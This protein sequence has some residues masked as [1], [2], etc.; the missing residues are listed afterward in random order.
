MYR[1]MCWVVENDHTGVINGVL[2][3]MFSLSLFSQGEWEDG[4]KAMDQAI[5][6][7]PRT[8]HRL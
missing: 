3:N 4:L 5:H 2:L 1:G 6:D 7:M 8:N